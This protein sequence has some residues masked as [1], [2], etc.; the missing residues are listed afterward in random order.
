M[1]RKLTNNLGLKLLAVVIAFALW[2]VVVN[3][4]DPI[5]SNTYSGIPVEVLHG[6][7]LSEQG[8]VYEVL[9]NTD[10]VTVVVTAKRSVLD[11]ISKENIKATADLK[12]LT[13][14]DTVAILVTTNKNSNQIESIRSETPALQLAIEALATKHFAIGVAVTGEPAEG[15]VT[16]DVTPNL[17]TV[18][19]SGPQSVVDSIGYAEINVN[20]AGRSSD[21]TTSSQIV[22]YDQD[23]KEIEHPGLN[24]SVSNVSVSATILATKA[25]EINYAYQG[26]PMDGYMVNGGVSADRSAVYIAGSVEDLAKVSSIDVPASVIDIE[27]ATTSVIKKINLKDY[28]PGSIVF[29]EKEYSGYVTATVTIEQTETKVYEVPIGNITAINVPDGLEAEIYLT[30]TAVNDEEDQKDVKVLVNTEGL[31]ESYESAEASSIIGIVDV[32][33]YAEALGIANIGKGDYLIEITF[34]LPEGIQMKEPSYAVVHL[35]E[36]ED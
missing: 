5:V 35:T 25:V 8:K 22:L 32:K 18:M 13:L 12:D 29:A 14:M 4:D 16:G 11:T 24:L 30:R 31:A 2:L 28:L 19:V 6:E 36:K 23:G 1:K 3:I 27:D 10:S 17:N 34:I 33:G 26:E 15:Y 9:G 20:V 21:M 7:S